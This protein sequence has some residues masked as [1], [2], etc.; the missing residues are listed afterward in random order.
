[1]I[2]NSNFTNMR[3]YLSGELG[4]TNCIL[5]ILINMRCVKLF[6]MDNKLLSNLILSNS[7]SLYL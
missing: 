2:R 5:L 4:L 1:M 3:F 6:F 7:L